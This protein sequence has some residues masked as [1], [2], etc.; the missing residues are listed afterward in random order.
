MAFS[1]TQLQGG[2]K[3]V[4]A[5]TENWVK[6]DWKGITAIYFWVPTDGLC[7][8][9][10]I[11]LYLYSGFLLQNLSLNLIL[12]ECWMLSSLPTSKNIMIDF[13]LLSYVC[14]CFSF[15]FCCPDKPF[16]GN[17]VD[18]IWV[19]SSSRRSLSWWGGTTV[20]SRHGGGSGSQGLTPKP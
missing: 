4:A 10:L 7:I 20:D 6:R 8:P 11:S 19:Y 14:D 1:A 17:G 5:S 2:G 12:K 18:F 3:V 13:Y 16:Q 9:I 15:F